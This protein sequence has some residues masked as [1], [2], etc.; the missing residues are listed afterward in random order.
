MEQLQQLRSL[1]AT[2]QHD[3]D[4]CAS[5]VS[6]ASGSSQSIARR[7]RY[8]APTLPATIASRRATPTSRVGPRRH[9][10]DADSTAPFYTDLA[11][12]ICMRSDGA[13][14]EGD[15]AAL[16][17]ANE[18]AIGSRGASGVRPSAKVS[19]GALRAAELSERPRFFVMGPTR[20][21]A[22]TT[23]PIVQR[24]GLGYDD[25]LESNVANSSRGIL[26]VRSTASAAGDSSPDAI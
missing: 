21:S 17:Y 25:T 9:S 2:A 10:A 3:S 11:N 5:L 14:I 20:Q 19:A 6:A 26:F 15:A 13:N 4:A 1:S 18:M 7:G 8:F 23:E 16:R 24:Y 12:S 22:P